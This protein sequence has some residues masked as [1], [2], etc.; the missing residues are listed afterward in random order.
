[1]TVAG[2]GGDGVA[3]GCQMQGY[4]PACGRVPSGP[5]V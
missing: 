2:G 4:D 1:M 5:L 3:G